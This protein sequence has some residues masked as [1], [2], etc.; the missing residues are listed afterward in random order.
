M[1]GPRDADFFLRRPPDRRDP[2]SCRPVS[3]P[4]GLG[5]AL[6]WGLAR[7]HPGLLG[8][9]G[10]PGGDR[11]GTPGGLRGSAG[12]PL[13]S[14]VPRPPPASGGAGG[15][16]AGGRAC[17]VGRS[18]EALRLRVLPAAPPRRA[19]GRTRGVVPSRRVASRSHALS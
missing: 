5:R 19:L 1:S 8:T 2:G 17:W 15:C 18:G 12:V 6:C 7:L 13:G 4:W 3:A 9:E 16:H 14:L 11:A 10:A